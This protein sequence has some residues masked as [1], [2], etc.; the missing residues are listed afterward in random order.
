LLV[1]AFKVGRTGLL[2]ASSNNEY[3]NLLRQANNGVK[4]EV[5]HIASNKSLVSG[6]TAQYEKI[7]K[8]AGMSL[9]DDENLIFLENHSGAHTNAYKQYVL[10]YLT[11]AIKGL[12]GDAA[13]EALTEALNELKEQ[14]IENPRMPY[15]GG[16]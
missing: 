10:R 15:K 14:L 5:H 16:L 2:F 9:D 3:K 7:F 4:G 11:N 8:N 12:K 6:Y 13:K 1:T